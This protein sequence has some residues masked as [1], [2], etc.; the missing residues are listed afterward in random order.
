MLNE[1]TAMPRCAF[2]LFLLVAVFLAATVARAD[3]GDAKIA[4]DREVAPL[5]ARRC[6]DCHN[7]PTPKGGLNLTSRKTALTGGDNG[8]AFVAGKPEESLL[9]QRVRDGE[10]PPKKSLPE[11]EKALLKAWIASGAAWGTDP[12]DPFR[13]TTDRRAGYDWWSLRPVVSH[14]P[15]AVQRPGWARNPID[16]FILHRLEARGLAPSPEADRRTLIRRLYFDLIGLPPAPEEVQAFVRD[17][18]PQ[19]YEKVVDRLLASPHHGERWARHWLDVVR[20]GESDG[21]ERNLPRPNAWHYRAWVVA[22]LN[23]DL[24]YEDFVRLQIAGDAL[25]PGSP[26][27]LQAAGF[28]VAGPHDIVVPVADAMKMA[29]RQDEMEDLLGTLGQTF[30]GLTV[31][32][33]RCHDH[34]FDPITQKDY[35]RLTA[36]LAGVA[37]GE[38]S[39]RAEADEKEIARVQGQ[40]DRVRKDLDDMAVPLRKQ[41]LAERRGKPIDEVRP[42]A[43]WRFAVGLTDQVGSLH[44]KL[45]GSTR[46]VPAGLVVDG[47]KAYAMSEPLARDLREKTLMVRVQLDNLAQQG[48]GAI[49]VQ[50]LD[51]NVFDAIVFGERESGCWMAGSNGFERTQSFGGPAEKDDAAR[52]VHFAI[53]YAADGTITGYRDG[54]IYGKSY[55]SRGVATFKAGAARVV[56]GVRHEPVGGNRMLAGVIHEA[57]LYDRALTAAE[58]AVAAGTGV[59]EAEIQARLNATEKQRRQALLQERARLEAEIGRRQQVGQEKV[60]TNVSVPPGPTHLLLRGQVTT[61][62]ERVD[63]GAIAALAPGLPPFALLPDAGEA[64]RRVALARW[65]TDPKNPLFARVLVNRLWHYHFGVGLVDT[66]NDFGFNGG[67]PS[68]PELLDWLAAEFARQNGS[69]KALHRLLVTSSAYR[70]G[71]GP[72]EDA[73]RIDADNRLLWRHIPVRLEAEAIRDAMLAVTGDL[74]RSV[75]GKGYMDTKSYFFKGTQFYDPVDQVGPAFYRRTLYRMWP[76]GGGSP[77]LDTFDCPD[78]STTTPR[79]AVTTT[80][81]QALALLNNAFVLHAADRFAERVRREAGAE[82]GSQ[83][84]RAYRL[85]YGRDPTDAEVRRVTPFVARHGLAALGR[86]LFNSSEFVQVD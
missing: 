19:A 79:R 74:D 52:P 67:R 11:D 85:A 6:L 2:L 75:G 30:L 48:G 77:L 31:N 38:R 72:R 51:G 61:P 58:I 86:V 83:V 49:T 70:Q 55:R 24:P 33:A 45:L 5:L 35:Y 56:F 76:R 27:G 46:L 62:G 36:T 8:P 43:E 37:H 59:T 78:P 54:R 3:R 17:A 73:L 64:D 53:T 68:H 21:F 39:L 26:E 22:A 50:T 1:Q 57:R 63:P 69:L 71:S 15:P 84:V 7:G 82:P 29:M 25:R 4:F 80:P 65:I 20:Y 9:W 10:M 41:V 81:A 16:R 18:D 34:K 40:L 60:F 28:L 66:P 42:L 13:I 47:Q 14:K 44:A 23:R 32:C 12:I